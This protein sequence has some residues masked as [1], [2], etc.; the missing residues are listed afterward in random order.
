MKVKNLFST[1]IVNAHISLLILRLFSGGLMLTHGW[2]K[3]M[4]FEQLSTKFPDPLH[5]GHASS[6][7]LAVF[8][9]I[10][11]AV[12]LILGLFTRL[13]SIPLIVTM[14]VAVFIVHGGDPIGKKELGLMYLSMYTV[15]LMMGG[16]KYSLDAKLIK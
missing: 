6:L 15:L 3:M 7:A 13:A 9:E 2:G 5:I 12:F 8:S 14:L 11:C 16:G 1:K 10:G 4:N